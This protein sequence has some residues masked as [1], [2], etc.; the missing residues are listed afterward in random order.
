MRKI[1]DKLIT[2]LFVIFIFSVTALFFALPKA[3]SSVNEKRTLAKPPKLSISAVMD[4]TFEKGV[5]DYLNDHFPMRDGWVSI[6]SYTALWTGR[7][8]ENGVYKGLDGYLINTPVMYDWSKHASETFNKNIDAICSFA[9]KT[10]IPLTLMIIPSSGSVM[11]EKLPKNHEPYPDDELI[12]AAAKMTAGKNI[13]FVDIR[14][15]L[16]NAKASNQLYYKTDH[17]WTSDGAYEA[18]AMLEPDAKAKS[19]FETEEYD[20]FFGTSYSKAALWHEKGEKIKLYTYPA[21][22]AV[23]ITDGVNTE[24]SND[25][26]YRTHLDE[27]DKYSVYLDGNHSYVR[28]E[29]SAEENG[30]LLIIK[31]SYAHCL[32][33][34]LALHNNVVDMVDLRYYL[35]SVSE[36]AEREN[37]DRILVV[38]GLSNLAEA[39][40]I[41]ILE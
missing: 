34:F 2:L 26:F 12:D 28:I 27:L 23:T 18:Y 41:N 15:R 4:G 11:E 39:T 24:T 40:D 30:R 3:E 20:G 8:G 32:A 19:E 10:D 38:Y 9:A 1:R 13:D 36:L 7:N 31:D 25:M 5:E 22:V 37:Y 35:E 29:N 21:E 33:P 14:G 6:E 17:H 16:K